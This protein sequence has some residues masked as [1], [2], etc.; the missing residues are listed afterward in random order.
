MSKIEHVRANL[1]LVGEPLAN[2]EQFSQLF[3]RGVK[4]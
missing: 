3:E 1:R 2:A 4:R